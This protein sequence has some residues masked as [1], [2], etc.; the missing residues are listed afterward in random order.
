MRSGWKK[1]VLMQLKRKKHNTVGP[2]YSKTSRICVVSL[3]WNDLFLVICRTLECWKKKSYLPAPTISKQLLTRT[4]DLNQLST[5]GS[6]HK[7]RLKTVAQ[8][9]G[10]AHFTAVANVL[11]QHITTNS[12]HKTYSQN[13][14]L[15]N[16]V[17]SEQEQLPLQETITSTGCSVAH[18]IKS[19]VFNTA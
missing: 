7:Q 17:Y 18:P 15:R 11:S 8:T 12:L 14:Q 6:L 10:L 2:L 4:I 1:M 16:L 19:F 5:T 9:P 13:P 3:L